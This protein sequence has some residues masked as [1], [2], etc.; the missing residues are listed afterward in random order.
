MHAE[1]VGELLDQIGLSRFILLL[2]LRVSLG[3]FEG[4]LYR[5]F[6]GIAVIGARV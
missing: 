5:M 3:F 1:H 6:R 2:E 4:V